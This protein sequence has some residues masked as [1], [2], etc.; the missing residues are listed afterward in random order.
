MTIPRQRPVFV[1]LPAKLRALLD[2]RLAAMQE[3]EPGI[4]TSDIVRRA[5]ARELA[6]EA[7]RL[8]GGA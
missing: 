4:T 2:L 3:T 6:P 1:R 5:L 7:E 8:K